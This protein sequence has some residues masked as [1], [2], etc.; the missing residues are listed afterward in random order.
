MAQNYRQ[1]GNVLDWA[2][3]TGSKVN[4]GDTVV[5]GNTVGIA[6]A[7]IEA[8][9]EGAIA[10]EGVFEVAKATGT[11]W[12]VGESVDY[13]V[14]AGNFAKGITPAGG[15]VTLAGICAQPAASNASTAWV[16]LTPGTGV[17]N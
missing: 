11:A 14:S 8:G 13:D 4:S 9:A 7:D 12:G 1:A 10:V 16:K 5:A 3:D 17:L 2:N 15:D 6:M